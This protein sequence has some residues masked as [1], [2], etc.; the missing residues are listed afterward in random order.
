MIRACSSFNLVVKIQLSHGGK[1]LRLP[2][3]NATLRKNSLLRMV[4]PSFLNFH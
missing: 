4:L 3:L 2:R 1:K